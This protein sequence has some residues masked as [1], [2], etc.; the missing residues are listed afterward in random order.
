MSRRSVVF[1]PVLLASMSVI[2]Q[3][4][5]DRA[6]GGVHPPGPPQEAI[7]A[8]AGLADAADCS[9]RSPR[10]EVSGSCRTLPSLTLCVPDRGIAPG[11]H[12]GRGP[13]GGPGGRR[14][15]PPEAFDACKGHPDGSE[16]R[17]QTPHGE[18]S[19]TCR[20]HGD[21]GFCLPVGGPPGR[22]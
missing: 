7:D 11:G 5:A 2:A 18:I 14:Q 16:C 4:D 6:G 17:V 21:G 1:V 22:S 3:V 8:C 13:R 12:A 10:G 15:P 20:D 19:G 9:F